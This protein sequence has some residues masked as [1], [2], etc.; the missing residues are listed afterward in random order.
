MIEQIDF[1]KMTFLDRVAVA[2]REPVYSA[3][4]AWA[5]GEESPLHL[6]KRIRILERLAE[7]RFQ[8]PTKITAQTEWKN[9]DLLFTVG[10]EPKPVCI[11][12]ENKIKAGESEEQLERY[13]KS[14]NDCAKTK[15]VRKIFLTLSGEQPSSGDGW[16]AVPYSKLRDALCEQCR[17]EE[18]PYLIDLCKSLSKLCAVADRVR[19]DEA[20]AAYVFRDDDKGKVP[21]DLAGVVESM[22]LRK[23]VQR[24]WM[25]EV[26]NVLNDIGAIRPPWQTV[27]SES[28]GEAILDILAALPDAAEVAV[29]FQLQ[30]RTLK[31]FCRP[32]PYP[33]KVTEEQSKRVDRVLEMLRNKF[34][35]PHERRPTQSRGRGFRSFSYLAMPEGRNPESWAEKLNAHLEVLYSHFPDAKEVPK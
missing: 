22:K 18:D 26:L 12:I 21:P 28:H 5:L 24:I 31:L 3:A 30:R 35:I 27:L 20:L 4:L 25:N 32:E 2:A 19:T 23:V 33:K 13:D 34:N 6:E 11:A 7:E 8:I 15:E 1:S 10:V 17:D 16:K 14:L 9:I 29:G